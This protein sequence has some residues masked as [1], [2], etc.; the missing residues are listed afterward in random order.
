MCSVECDSECVGGVQER[1]VAAVST[2]DVARLV[3]MELA[4]P[5]R[6]LISSDGRYLFPSGTSR[7]PVA[8]RSES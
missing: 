7:L 5:V 2:F 4:A 8:K 1:Q 3:G 6:T